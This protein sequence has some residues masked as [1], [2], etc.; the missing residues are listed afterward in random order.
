MY[1]AQ[2]DSQGTITALL[3]G[4]IDTANTPGIVAISAQDYDTAR[5]GG[6]TFQIQNGQL[7]SIPLPESSTDNTNNPS[8]LQ[9]MAQAIGLGSKT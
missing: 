4:S 6:A 8:L 7:V 9:K 2:T 3:Q 1:Y 5:A